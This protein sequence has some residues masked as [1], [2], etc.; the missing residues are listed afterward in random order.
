M[1]HSV[2]RADVCCLVA[3]ASWTSCIV[4]ELDSEFISESMSLREKTVQILLSLIYCIK[5][6]KAA[7]SENDFGRGTLAIF[8]W[9]VVFM[10]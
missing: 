3:G 4:S 6:P 10:F 1:N 5:L 9:G 8:Y 7:M 2:R